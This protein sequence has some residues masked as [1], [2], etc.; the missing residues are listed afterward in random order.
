[1]STS[2]DAGPNNRLAAGPIG[3]AV[4]W[5]V[6]PRPYKNRARLRREV[7]GKVAVVTGASFGV[8]E[9]TARILAD[10]GATVV[11]GARSAEQLNLIVTEIKAAGGRAVAIPLD[12]ASEDS[13]KAFAEQVLTQ[14]GQV[15]YLVHNAGKSLRRSIHLSYDRPKD[16]NATTAAN[17]LGPM[18]LTLAL[19]PKMRE[20]GCGHI[21]NVS[22]AGLMFPV[23]PKWGFYLSSKA[24][25]DIW[26]RSVAMEARPDGVTLTS[27]YAGAMFTRMSAPSGWVSALPGHSARDAGY[28]I[29][30]AIVR[31]PRTLAP[32]VVWPLSVLVPLLRTP[33]EIGATFLYRF[34][35]DTKA[36]LASAAKEAGN[37]A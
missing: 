31:K 12:L 1:M 22:T 29:A 21:V 6:G 5:L 37:V 8:G 7:D 18:R 3:R 19:L 25:F 28:I 11:L 10:A 32:A 13:V 20:R 14:F 30:R 23:A 15:D 33:L 17:Y 16:L 35:G 34:L 26:I 27:F 9:A 36:S 24:A 2:L 4:A